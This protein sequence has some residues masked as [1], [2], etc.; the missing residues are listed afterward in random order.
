MN[1]M[2]NIHTVARYEARLL[3]RSWLFRIFAGLAVVGIFL[4]VGN[5]CT[6][7]FGD[8]MTRW[9]QVALSGQIPFFSTY[10][11]H[12]LQAVAVVFL[13]LR[14]AGWRRAGR[15]TRWTCSMHGR[16]AT[17]ISFGARCGGR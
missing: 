13:S 2:K 3:R 9:N 1:S 7:L 5:W 10:L 12:I 17:G 4:A 6:P 8:G 14:V 16:L 15:Q 11:F